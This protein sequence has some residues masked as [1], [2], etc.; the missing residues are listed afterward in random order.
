MS[1]GRLQSG[2]GGV[3]VLVTA[4]GGYFA[5]KADRTPA[6]PIPGALGVAPVNGKELA[7]LVHACLAMGAG[8]TDSAIRLARLAV[9]R[10]IDPR[11]SLVRLV[12]AGSRRNWTRPA[13][14]DRKTTDRRISSCS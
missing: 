1:R 12:L 7:W 11:S 13:S 2:D 14:D 6:G 4:S 10:Y 9:D 8:F 5:W 3:A